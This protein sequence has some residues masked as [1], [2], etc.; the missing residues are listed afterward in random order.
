MNFSEAD[1]RAKL[2]D[3]KLKE[4][5][6]NENF[7][8]REYYFTDGRKLVGNQRTKR[9]FVDYL[10][11]YKNINLAIIEAKKLGKK[12]NRRFTTSN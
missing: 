8:I 4:S 11:R 6:W 2:I 5:L 12:T 9:L 10:L 3:P 1:T 7:I